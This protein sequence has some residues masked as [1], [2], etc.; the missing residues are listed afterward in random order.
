MIGYGVLILCA[1]LMPVMAVADVDNRYYLSESEYL[2]PP[3]KYVL[4]MIDAGRIKCTANLVDGK[5]I[6]A[7]HCL[8]NYIELPENCSGYDA[9]YVFQT[10]DGAEITARVD[11]C[12]DYR[13]TPD[14]LSGDWA[15]LTPVTNYVELEYADVCTLEESDEGIVTGYGK[16][17]VLTDSDVTN[18]VHSYLRFLFDAEKGYPMGT[19][20]NADVDSLAEAVEALDTGVTDVRSEDTMCAGDFLDNASYYGI[21]A[22][23]WF[24]DAKE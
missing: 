13:N 1:L 20:K 2:D 5:I 10:L 22:N 14:T 11:A 4:K 18:F 9:T 16:L 17:K 15:V 3:H 8:T 19:S 23:E 12:G 6:T 24:D 21:D 7:K